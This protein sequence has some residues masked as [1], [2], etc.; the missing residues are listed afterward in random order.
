MKKLLLFIAIIVFAVGIFLRLWQLNRVPISLFG[1]E[2]DVGLQGN[3][4]LTTGKDYFG[5][6]FPLMFHSF[7]EYRLPMQLYLAA[8]FI[9][10]FGLN[11]LG[12]RG[13]AVLMGLLSVFSFYLLTKELFGKKV[14]VIS[15]L[16]L[17]FSPWH[18]NFSRQ[19][20]DAGILLP[21]VILGTYFF[22]KGRRD[23]KY[24]VISTVLFSLS[25]YTYAISTLFVPLFVIGLT[26]LFRKE[27]FKYGIKKLAFIGILGLLILG[28]Y[29]NWSVRGKTT[30]RISDISAIPKSEV[31]AEVENA[32]KFVGGIPG[33]LFYNKATVIVTRLFENYTQAFSPAFLFA[34]GDA[35][36]RNSVDEFGQMYH[37]D[38]ILTLIG[39]C[40]VIYGLM[41]KKGNEKEFWI[42]VL[43]LILAPI[44][45]AFT[46]GGG[47]H[48]SRLIL[49]LPPLILLSSLGFESLMGIKKSFLRKAVLAIT[50][51]IMVFEVTR[52][53]NHYFVVWPV[54]NWRLWQYG[55]KE[56]IEFV[57]SQ[58]KNY[59]K[60]YLNSTYEPMLPRFLFYY[61]YEMASFQK[62][63]EKDTFD[64]QIV[65]GMDGFKLG[66]KYYFGDLK[67]PIENLADPNI[68][69]VASAEKDA[70]NPEIFNGR[71]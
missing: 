64:K 42:L 60:I 13:P 1:D 37:L 56:T 25:I 54:K 31:V 52:F 71:D 36:T 20:N 45:S 29:I 7:A 9:K 2:I 12:V 62:E 38:A 50:I 35:N 23:F 46:K 22:L 67:K 58:D 5:N 26:V 41:A 51:L 14:A 28:P 19:A 65:P 21:F 18:F 43:W 69:V 15:S 55:F 39:L 44:P 70:T 34:R 66:E 32:R 3:S 11:E 8:P 30:K 27:I 10:V 16:F 48:A 6:K 47:A 63:F 68:L 17:L 4:I 61:K 24:L 40:L 53:M 33:K 49:M 59:Q 57:K